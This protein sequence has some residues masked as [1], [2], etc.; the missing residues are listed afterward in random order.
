VREK[1]ATQRPNAGLPPR[2]E[3]AQY[4]TIVPDLAVEVVSPND[5]PADVAAKV[6][7]Y[8]AHGVLLVWV[9]YPRSPRV[10]VHQPGQEPRTLGIADTLGGGEILPG[11]HLP[12]ASIFD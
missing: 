10:I 8:V 2:D 4:P 3:W 5:E 7:F 11:F 9:V 12:V 6:T 1:P